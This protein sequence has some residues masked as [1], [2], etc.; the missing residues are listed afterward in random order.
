MAWMM[1]GW[2][3]VSHGVPVARDMVKTTAPEDR[4]PAAYWRHRKYTQKPV[5]YL[6]VGHICAELKALQF[7]RGVPMHEYLRGGADA[8]IISYRNWSDSG[9]LQQGKSVLRL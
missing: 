9:S 3:S 8:S 7:P 2:H 6:G 4:Y 5:V 1:V